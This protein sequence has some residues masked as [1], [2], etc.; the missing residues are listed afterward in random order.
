MGAGALA[1]NA[2]GP[3]PPT[4]TAP[5]L[6]SPAPGSSSLAV[7]LTAERATVPIFSGAETPVWRFQA[8]VQEG[9]G[10]SIQTLKGSYLGLIFRVKKG[11][12]VQIQLKNE[13]SDP[14]IV[15]WHGLRV[16]E[17]MDGHPRDAI[18]PR[19]SYKYD[20]Q[21]INR[22]GTYWF[23]PQP[24][25]L[26]G[27]QV[28]YGLAGLFIVSDEEEAELGLPFGEYDLP[29]VIQDRKFDSQN[30]MV[31][32]TNGMMDQMIGFLGDT[33]LVNGV[34]NASLDIKASA[35]R[36]RLL[37]GSNSRIYKLAW[38]D[39]TPLMVIATDG[40]LLGSPVVRDY[41]TLAP[42]ERVELWADF[43]RQSAGNEM[44]LV[45][46]PFTDFSGGMMGGMM[47]GSSLP[48]GAPL[49]ILSLKIGKKGTEVTPKRDQL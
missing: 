38:E 8:S 48:N 20:F 31:Y 11:Q 22:A 44:Q 1:L 16:P 37:N 6:F 29:L 23:H 36:L 9:S 30:K 15:H 25:Q 5:T 40:G 35:Y 2:C 34:P 13:L 45:S 10:G 21:V 42:A 43:S 41:I 12:R 33:I 32:L 27:P 46:L 47:G 39:G 19:A 4:T 18:A 26:T 17:E 49:D 28:Y 3:N 7:D 24:D 14:T